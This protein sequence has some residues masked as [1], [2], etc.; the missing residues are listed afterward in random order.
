M[1]V[2]LVL[3]LVETGDVSANPSA[4][5]RGV[6]DRQVEAWN[7]GDIAGYMEGY[8]R[9]DSVVFTS[10]GRVHRGWQATFETYVARYD[11]HE[12]MGTLRFSNL[13][14]TLLSDGSAFILGSWE[15]LRADDRPHGIF[16]LVLRRFVN[17]W[18][19]IH[20]HTSSSVD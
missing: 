5:I 12:K 18:R 20:D 13:E 6:L 16:T 4:E 11:T 9:S 3:L 19:I 17:G 1:I 2:V 8:W 7:D 15:L 14:I 10:G